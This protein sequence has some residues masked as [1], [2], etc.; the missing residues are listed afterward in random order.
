MLLASVVAFGDGAEDAVVGQLCGHIFE[1]V[2]DEVDLFVLQQHFELGGPERL[3]V[4]FVQGGLEVVIGCGGHGV[5]LEVMRR[6]VFLQHADDL[7]GLHA[8]EE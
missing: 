7:V 8:G 6:P 4:E 5:D 3:F 1:G 2:D